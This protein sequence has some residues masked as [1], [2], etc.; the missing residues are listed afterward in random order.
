MF[1]MCQTLFQV[2]YAEEI[3]SHNN[4]MSFNTI[5]ILIL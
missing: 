3:N 4:F 5:I 2:I 1:L